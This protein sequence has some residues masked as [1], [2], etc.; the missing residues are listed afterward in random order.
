MRTRTLRSAVVGT[1]RPFEGNK[2]GEPQGTAFGV[3]TVGVARLYTTTCG[4]SLLC[5]VEGPAL[6]R[7]IRK[8][9]VSAAVAGTSWELPFPNEQQSASEGQASGDIP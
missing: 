8:V 3:H 5:D 1:K 7:Q 2:S 4:L 9:A 6:C